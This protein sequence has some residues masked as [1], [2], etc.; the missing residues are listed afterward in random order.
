MSE[1]IVDYDKVIVMLNFLDVK[2]IEVDTVSS[3]VIVVLKGE[4]N[5]Q[6][7]SRYPE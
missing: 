4:D 7:P 6:I 1:A 5:C 3:K 2:F